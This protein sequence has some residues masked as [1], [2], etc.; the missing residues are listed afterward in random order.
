MDQIQSLNKLFQNLQSKNYLNSLLFRETTDK[1]LQCTICNEILKNEV[2]WYKHSKSEKHINGLKLLKDSLSSSRLKTE[3]SGKIQ[4]FTP[5]HDDT[6]ESNKSHSDLYNTSVEVK[7]GNNLTYEETFEIFQRI[8][9]PEKTI[10]NVKTNV[11]KIL[12]ENDP[13]KVTS[14]L[15]PEV[16]LNLIIA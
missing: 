9:I 13:A 10:L 1:M 12:K 3:N 8:P 4:N 6:I 7:H 11:L 16:K 5:K 15:V 14:A 2:F